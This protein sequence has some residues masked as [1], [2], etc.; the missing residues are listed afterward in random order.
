MANPFDSFSDTQT[1]LERVMQ[2]LD[3]TIPQPPTSPNFV[4]PDQLQAELQRAFDIHA[5]RIEKVEAVALA[6]V[7]IQDLLIGAM[8]DL[9][10]VNPDRL[11]A[12]LSDLASTQ[13]NDTCRQIVE[14]MIDK[15]KNRL[16]TDAPSERHLHLVPQSEERPDDAD[17]EQ[18]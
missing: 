6:Q 4:D 8:V 18:S 10:M 16:D 15:V 7:S 17:Q 1:Q 2:S 12:A 3:R 5:K 11:I 13:S 14:G 9:E